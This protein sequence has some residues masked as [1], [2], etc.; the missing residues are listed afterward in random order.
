MPG[1]ER[2]RQS[3]QD[4]HDDYVWQINA[5][6]EEGRDDLVWKLADD[7]LDTALRTMTA[8]HPDGCG[9]DHCAL[10]MRPSAPPRP[11]PRRRWW[12]RLRRRV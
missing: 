7:Y 9:R 4:L 6:V 12:N 8:M 5:A 10:C 1:D 2:E 11:A 3:L